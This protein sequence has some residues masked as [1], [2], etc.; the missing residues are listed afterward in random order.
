MACLKLLGGG[1]G[2]VKWDD[3]L[4]FPVKFTSSFL[5][6]GVKFITITIKWQLVCSFLLDSFI[7]L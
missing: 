1:G 4:C 2:D 5:Y 3:E 6:G 7:C